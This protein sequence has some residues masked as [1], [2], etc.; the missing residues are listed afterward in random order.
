[1]GELNKYLRRR[2]QSENACKI[3]QR[4]FISSLLALILYRALYASISMECNKKRKK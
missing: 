4:N 3:K 1:M 2:A